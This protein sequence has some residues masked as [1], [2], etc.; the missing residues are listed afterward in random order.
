[1]VPIT[2]DVNNLDSQVI[3][4]GRVLSDHAS[5]WPTPRIE[6]APTSQSLIGVRNYTGTSAVDSGG[7]VQY[8]GHFNH[9]ERAERNNR[10]GTSK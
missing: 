10:D 4:G 6:T 8:G 2:R 3:R 5:L 9:P 1:M 7:R